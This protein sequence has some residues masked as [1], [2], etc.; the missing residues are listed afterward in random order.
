M[1]LRS[2]QPISKN[3]LA[4]LEKFFTLCERVAVTGSAM[5]VLGT[6]GWLSFHLHMNL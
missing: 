4:S 5:L 6:I 2:N 1:K 3:P